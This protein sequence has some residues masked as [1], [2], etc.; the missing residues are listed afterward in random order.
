MRFGA[1]LALVI[2]GLSG[3]VG[4]VVKAHRCPDGQFVVDGPLFAVTQMPSATDAIVIAGRQVSIASGCDARRAKQLVRTRKGTRLQ[5]RW[6]QCGEAARVRLKGVISKDC[7]HFTGTLNA[8]GIGEKTLVGIL[9]P[10]PP[11]ELNDGVP[12][13]ETFDCGGSAALDAVETLCQLFGVSPCVSQSHTCTKVQRQ[14]FTGTRL[15]NAP[16]DGQWNG[17]GGTGDVMADALLCTLREL[18]PELGGPITST[19]AVI[20]LGPLGNLSVTQEVGFTGFDRLRERF[21]GYRRIVVDM[22][23]IGQAQAIS[24]PIVFDKL[25]SN[26]FPLAAGNYPIQFA[27]AL[28]VA[29]EDTEKILTFTPPGFQVA[30]PLGPVTVSPSFAYGRRSAVVAAP[31][32]NANLANDIDSLYVAQPWTV[33]L[34]DL[35]GMTPGLANTATETT[36]ANFAS[37]RSGWASQLGFGTR[38]AVLGESPWAPPPSGRITRPDADLTMPRSDVE[39]VPSVYVNAHAD[40][41]WPSNPYDLLP[42]WVTSIPFLNPPIAQ[43]SVSPTVDVGVLGELFAALG[44]GADHFQPQEFRFSSRRLSTMA[45]LAGTGAVGLF[46]VDAGVRISVTADFP[47]PVGSQTFVDVDKKFPIPLASDAKTGNVDTAGAVALD[48]GSPSFPPVV[49]ALQ[50]F[51]GL[52]AGADE[53]QAFIDACYAPQE[54]APQPI[55]APAPTPGH[56][57][58]LLN[59]AEWPCNICVYTAGNPTGSLTSIKQQYEAGR[60]MHPEWPPWPAS[61]PDEWIQVLVP[62]GTAPV[63]KCNHYWDTGCYDLCSFD[64]VS[65]ALA[66]VKGPSEIIPLLPPTPDYDDERA[67]LNECDY[68]PPA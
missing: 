13:T 56:P 67:L 25:A 2:V 15:V 53:V 40:V 37:R 51:K 4:A 5:V 47:F 55:P 60:A 28:D 58:D 64:P 29:S 61:V 65:H 20:S 9:D 12:V 19:P 38:G 32:E 41:K 8:K 17:R 48:D 59:G 57:A 45:L 46:R 44:E 62:A 33:R 34:F 3:P 24:Q 27:Y 1:V 63:W 43:L 31:Y 42:S 54:L 36:V 39:A 10:K 7:T 35:Y 18:S 30:T 11:P 22:P 66:V 49:S 50:T 21:E 68:E 26:A 6:R 14:L 52:H 16:G 23:V